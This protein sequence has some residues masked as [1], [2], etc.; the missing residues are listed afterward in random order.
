MTA[1]QKFMLTAKG[2]ALASAIAAVLYPSASPAPAEDG[3]RPTLSA[4]AGASLGRAEAFAERL[5]VLE[6][7]EE[8]LA[9]AELRLE[10]RHEMLKWGLSVF[11]DMRDEVTGLLEATSGDPSLG[12]RDHLQNVADLLVSRLAILKEATRP[13]TEAGNGAD[14]PRVVM[15]SAAG[16]GVQ[17][18][19]ADVETLERQVRASAAVIN[20]FS[21]ENDRIIRIAGDVAV[22]LD[23]IVNA[24]ADENAGLDELHLPLIEVSRLLEEYRSGPDEEPSPET[25]ARP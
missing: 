7:R 6:I 18:L 1:L 12:P 16:I 9:A 8:A 24:A 2:V 10:E 15:A 22:E 11:S 23:K 4:D 20:R 3:L 25:A 5:A 21:S 14:V 17:D 19:S 13:E